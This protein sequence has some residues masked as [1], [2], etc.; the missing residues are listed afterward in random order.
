MTTNKKKNILLIDSNSNYFPTITN[1]IDLNKSDL[2]V[3]DSNE[4]NY[5]DV[6]QMIRNKNN[7]YESI[8]IFHNN[9]NASYYQ[10]SQKEEQCYLE[11]D[12]SLLTPH[13]K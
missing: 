11:N 2:I 7:N 9:S 10:F 4:H 8:G 1:Y 5:N 6:I 13:D 3:F 12:S